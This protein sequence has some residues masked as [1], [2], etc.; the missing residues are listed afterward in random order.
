MGCAGSAHSGR[1]LYAT[2]LW[3]SINPGS[4]QALPVSTTG[5]LVKPAGADALP[6]VTASTKPSSLRNTRPTNDASG[7]LGLIAT[8]RPL[9]TKDMTAPIAPGSSR[10]VAETASR[11]IPCSL[12]RRFVKGARTR[13]R[14]VWPAGHDLQRYGGQTDA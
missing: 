7:S 9:T 2:W 5:A 3:K 6:A 8:M 12:P 14:C 13:V 11:A 10:R 4:T 1:A